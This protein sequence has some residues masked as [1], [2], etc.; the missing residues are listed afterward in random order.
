MLG[1]KRKRTLDRGE[2]RLGQVSRATPHFGQHGRERVNHVSR[3]LSGRK[4]AHSVK[5]GQH[6]FKIGEFLGLEACQ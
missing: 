5:T 1:R 3:R 2:I 4:R 6:R